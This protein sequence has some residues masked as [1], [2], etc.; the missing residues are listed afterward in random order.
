MLY[1]PPTGSVSSSQRCRSYTHLFPVAAVQGAAGGALPE[2]LSW[3]QGV[4]LQA[5]LRVERSSHRNLILTPI[6]QSRCRSPLAVGVGSQNSMKRRKTRYTHIPYSYGPQAS[7]NNANPSNELTQKKKKRWN[8]QHTYTNWFEVTMWGSLSLGSIRDAATKIKVRPCPPTLTPA[9][10][11][12][13]S[14]CSLK[15]TRGQRFMVFDFLFA[16]LRPFFTQI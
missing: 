2:S 10:A 7:P 16:S 4:P 13:P 5:R 11:R 9:G 1:L 3:W 15:K 6:S 8:K 14:L 12:Q